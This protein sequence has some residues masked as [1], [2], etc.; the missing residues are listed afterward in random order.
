MIRSAIDSFGR[1]G[2]RFQGA[3]QCASHVANC[4]ALFLII[5]PAAARADH[6]VLL[7]EPQKVQYGTR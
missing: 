2:L 6:N 3:S 5:W 4:S 1:V 7:P